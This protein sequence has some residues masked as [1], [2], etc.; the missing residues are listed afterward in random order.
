M[1][2]NA[3]QWWSMSRLASKVR[4]LGVMTERPPADLRPS[5]AGWQFQISKLLVVLFVAA[6]AGTGALVVT[7]LTGLSD[8]VPAGSGPNG[9]PPPP[10]S[11]RPGEILTVV[12]GLFVLAWLAV[13]IVFVR[14]QILQ[15]Q[16]ATGFGGGVSR[17]ELAGLLAGLRSEMA[18]DNAALGERLIELTGEYGERR[19]TDGYL[20]GMRMATSDD[21]SPAN[22]RALRRTPPQR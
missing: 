9:M 3:R 11:M 6:V 2:R 22:V 4:N 7:L 15:R 19:E 18:A 8:E 16:P 20:S 5:P 12:T 13:L 14:D 10:P 17:E 21:P 1:R